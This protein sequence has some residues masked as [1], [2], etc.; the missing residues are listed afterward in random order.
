MPKSWHPVFSASVKWVMMF[1]KIG[2]LLIKYSKQKLTIKSLIK[3]EA[4]GV[5]D[6]LPNI[7]LARM[8]HIN[9]LY[10]D[11]ESFHAGKNH[12]TLM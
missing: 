8:F 2:V 6:Y 11:M 7:I 10:Q 12:V 4:I 9:I 5:N 1:G 3:S